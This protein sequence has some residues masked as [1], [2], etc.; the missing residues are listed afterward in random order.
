[1]GL[2]L[3]MKWII[4]PYLNKVQVTNF[5]QTDRQLQLCT[6]GFEEI[7]QTFLVVRNPYWSI[8]AA[9]RFI[10]VVFVKF[11]AWISRLSLTTGT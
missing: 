10:S 3:T 9:D 8:F 5:N 7:L 6:L 4:V 11:L 1:M 2:Q